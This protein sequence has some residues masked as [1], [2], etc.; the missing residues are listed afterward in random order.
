MRS[1]RDERSRKDRMRALSKAKADG[2]YGL[3]GDGER[4]DE[5]RGLGG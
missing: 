3:S 2:E 5:E 1:Y 4:S